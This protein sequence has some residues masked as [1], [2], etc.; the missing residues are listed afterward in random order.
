MQIIWILMIA[1]IITICEY[2]I[3]HYHLPRG[4]LFIFPIINIC[5]EIYVIF[6]IL[7]MQALLTSMF[8][9]WIRIG[10]YL[11]P[12]LLSLL[13]MTG[14]L[15]RRYVRMAHTK[16]LRHIIYRLFAFFLISMLLIFLATVYLAQEYVIFY[17]N[18]NSQDRDALINTPDF[19]QISINSRYRGWLRNVDNADSILL[20]FGGNAQNTS[21]LFKDYMESGIF[22]TMT[23]TGFL[24]IDYPSY[25]DSEGSL[26]EDELFKMAEATIQY[27]QHSFPHKKLY[28]VGYSIGTGIASY[29][30]YLAHP[31][32]LVLLSPYNNG[33]DLFNSFFPVFYGPLQYLIRYPLTSDVYVKAL[34]CKSMVILSDKD[35]IVKP[36]LSKKLIQSFLKPPLVVHF[37]TL[38]HGD[39]AMSKDVWKTIMNFL[40]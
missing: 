20:Y 17:P 4:L 36:M 33:K 15:V 2:L 14:L 38:K 22:S 10:V 5:I 16:P 28:I 24:S 3:Y 26:S 6:Y 1:A 13:V 19:E 30:A 35:T 9:L 12:L 8:P 37:D 18:A 7:R 21:T 23:S 11:L 34:D 29:A 39:I 25:G 31:D 40:R 27:I 32:A